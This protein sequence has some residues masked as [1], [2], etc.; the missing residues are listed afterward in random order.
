MSEAPTLSRIER[1]LVLSVVTVGTLMAVLDMTI[2]NVALPNIMTSL[3]ANVKQVKWVVTAYMIAT[4]VG[5]P[6]TGWLGRRFGLGRLFLS[7]L[8]V[9]TVG[10]GLCA[11]AWNLDVLVFARVVQAL[12]AGAIMPTSMAIITDT[13]PPGERGRALG[14]WGI[15][16]MVGPAIGPTSGGLLTEWFNW[17]AIFAINLPVGVVGILFTV[18][19]L[20][21]GRKDPSLRFDW[22]GYL[23]LASFL[24]AG[25]LTLDS[26]EDEGWNSQLILFGAGFTCASFLLFL[27]LVWDSPHPV[28]P[29][30]LFRLPVFSLSV[31]LGFLR[32]AA[33][34]GAFFM[35]PLFLQNV[36]GRDTLDTGLL[37]VPSALAVAVTMPVAGILTDR[38]G[39]RWPSVAGFV[40]A[41][42]S[43]YLYGAMDPL[44]DRWAVIYPQ[45]WRGVGVAL[46]MTPV[47]T[48]AMNSVPREDAGVASW[49]VNLTQSAGGALTIAL[50]GTLLHRGT[51]AQMD[52]LGTG[53]ALTGPPPQLL[54]HQALL[55]GYSPAESGSVASAVL[56]RQVSLSATTLAFQDL[57]MLL[58]L[59]TLIGLVPALM[60]PTRRFGG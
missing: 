47:N 53:S 20:P 34:F 46:L 25:L 37:M 55:M 15:G 23:A 45:L 30:R 43:L 10:S 56:L 57:Y 59:L 19:A 48:A 44:V 26:G 28:L 54:V 6:M 31:L 36:Q 7:E 32:S 39:P 35:L 12:G 21:S 27:V 1:L 22:L 51:I 38:F 49:M 42:Y 4:A 8:I 41:S 17:R 5:M 2:V 14:I 9:F 29:L 3:A 33:F 50:L 18:L 16:F 13:F 58:A 40:L 60:L 24:V 52:L 11:A